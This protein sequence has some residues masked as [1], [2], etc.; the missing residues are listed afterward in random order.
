VIVAFLLRALPIEDHEGRIKDDPDAVE[1]KDTGHQNEVV[2]TAVES[3]E[4]GGQELGEGEN[5]EESEQESEDDYDDED[6]DKGGHEEMG[7]NGDADSDAEEV[8][9]SGDNLGDTNPRLDELRKFLAGHSIQKNG[10]D[11]RDPIFNLSGASWREALHPRLSFLAPMLRK[12]SDQV[13]P[14]YSLVSPPT[15]ELH[16]HEAVQ[17]ILLTSIWS[18]KD[19]DHIALDR[20]LRLVTI[21]RYEVMVRTVEPLSFSSKCSKL[22]DDQSPNVPDKSKHLLSL[23]FVF[24]SYRFVFRGEEIQDT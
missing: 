20:K 15:K 14:E 19:S 2:G 13:C 18:M 11:S 10:A 6:E 8:K 21:K 3:E 16:L 24:M 12:L 9:P 7:D 1:G 17:R 22:D 23:V 4:V 5:E